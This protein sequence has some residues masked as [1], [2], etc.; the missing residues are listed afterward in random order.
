MLTLSTL[1]PLVGAQASTIDLFAR[2]GVARTLAPCLGCDEGG[3]PETYSQTVENV[4]FHCSQCK[5]QIPDERR[6]H[7]EA[8]AMK[9]VQ[10]RDNREAPDQHTREQRALGRGVLVSWL[11]T[12]AQ[13]HRDVRT[14][15]PVK[16]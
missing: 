16:P 9:L 1:F 4:S 13:E 5:K 15:F 11:E 14:H 10:D 12:F 7:L 8:A 6:R 3:Y 2:L